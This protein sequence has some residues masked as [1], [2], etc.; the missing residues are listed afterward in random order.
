VSN[1]LSMSIR[2]I[3]Y[4]LII[5]GTKLGPGT[6]PARSP[7]TVPGAKCSRLDLADQFLDRLRPLY[8]QPHRPA[9]RALLKTPVG[10]DAQDAADRGQKIGDGNGSVEDGRGVLVGAADDLPAGNA[11]AG[12]DRASGAGVVVPAAER[13]RIQ[14]VLPS[15]R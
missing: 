6:R 5:A 14:V 3:C 4:D 11:A 15:R 7:P 12:Q 8:H 9:G 1:G 13:P 10:V 2:W